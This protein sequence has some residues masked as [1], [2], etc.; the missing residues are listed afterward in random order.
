M[1]AVGDANKE[2]RQKV[3]EAGLYLALI[4]DEQFD[5]QVPDGFQPCCFHQP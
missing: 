5:L 3:I 4:H 2:M 1:V